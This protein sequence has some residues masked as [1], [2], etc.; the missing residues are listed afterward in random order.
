[1]EETEVW[2]KIKGFSR[3]EISNFGRIRNEKKILKQQ[4]CLNGYPC[5]CL[6]NDFGKTIGRR[7][8][9]LLYYTYYDK[10]EKN[11]YSIDHI[12]R[13]RDDNRLE[14]LR[15]I[16]IKEQIKN[17]VISNKNKSCRKIYRICP[18]TNKILAEYNSIKDAKIWIKENT[19]YSGSNC[20]S[21]VAKK[22]GK[23]YNFIWKYKKMKL[24]KMK[25]GN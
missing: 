13:I 6:V 14:N 2:K 16:S 9:S 8:H 15:E 3:Y 4:K 21:E 20:L 23:M 10:I 7:I 18:N 11:N 1:M 25:N 22:N 12:N 19:K 5:I 17:R 24:L